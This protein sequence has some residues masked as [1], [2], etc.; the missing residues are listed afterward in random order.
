MMEVMDQSYSTLEQTIEQIASNKF[1]DTAVLQIGYT[2][3]NFVSL[4][5]ETD[6]KINL[7]E[8]DKKNI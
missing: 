7:I 2:N 8:N 4:D 3:Q 1:I 6:L 5:C